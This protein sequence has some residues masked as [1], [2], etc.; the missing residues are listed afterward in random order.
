MLVHDLRLQ[1]TAPRL[2]PNIYKVDGAT[3]ISHAFSWIARYASS[4]RGLDQLLIMCHGLS[5]AIVDNANQE[6]AMELGFGLMLCRENLTLSNVALTSVLQGLVAEIVLLACGPGKTRRGAEFTL[7]DGSRF[8]SELAAYTNAEVVASSETQWYY[9]LPPSN[10][11]RRLF[12]IGPQ[13]TIDFGEWEGNVSRYS[14]TGSV[15]A[16]Q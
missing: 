4:K 5:G 16:I 12:N 10:L 1:G 11:L 7:A 15:K 8:C 13:D 6:S 9:Q 14:P 3:P 2:A